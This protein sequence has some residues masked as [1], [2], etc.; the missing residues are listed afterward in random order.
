MEKFFHNDPNQPAQWI[1]GSGDQLFKARSPAFDHTTFTDKGHYMRLDMVATSRK[2]NGGEM[3]KADLVSQL[4]EPPEQPDSCRIRYYYHFTSRH[5]EKQKLMV[6][7]RTEDGEENPL[8]EVM[9]DFSN[10]WQRAD[11]TLYPTDKKYRVV[12]SAQYESSEV[13]EG[14]IAIDDVSFTPSCRFVTEVPTSSTPQTTPTTTHSSTTQ[15][16][17]PDNQFSCGDGATCID[18]TKVCD[19]YPDCPD[20]SDENICPQMETF[21]GCGNL[22]ECHWNEDVP[23]DLDFQVIKIQ[24]IIDG[25]LTDN[26][27]PYVNAFNSTEGSVALIIPQDPDNPDYSHYQAGMTSPM[28]QNSMSECYVEF[29]YYIAGKIGTN[30]A[31]S[32][33]LLTKNKTHEVILDRL[34]PDSDGVGIWRKSINGIGRQ[35][36]EFWIKLLLDPKPNF[37][38]GVA[39][40]D[41][42]YVACGRKP[43]MEECPSGFFHCVVTKACV[44]LDQ[45]CDLTDQCGDNSDEEVEQCHSTVKETFENDE[46]PLG[47][48]TQNA[49]HADFEWSRGS[50]QG[51]LAAGPPFDHTTFDDTGHYVYIAVSFSNRQD[52]NF[53]WFLKGCGK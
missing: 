35:R 19:F 44:P 2:E 50:G 40:D 42:G 36:G 31:L 4:M 20:N 27:G 32:P 3:L 5:P 53:M 15:I 48:F 12:F 38:A 33:I 41:V 1:R 10:V 7:I 52:S 49:D 47:V 29:W 18:Q 28:H 8:A 21:D 39:I 11:F 37:D 22:N 51:V 46:Q 24:A 17:C 43:A 6:A 13:S 23:D 9:E 14:D 34:K 16:N 26:H 45:L 25:E 30:G